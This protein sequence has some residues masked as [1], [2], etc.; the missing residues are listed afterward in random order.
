MA[1]PHPRPDAPRRLYRS[2]TERKIRGVCGGIAQYFGIDPRL[3]RIIAVM[4]L[5]VPGA[6]GLIAS[7]VAELTLPEEPVAPSEDGAEQPPE[8]QA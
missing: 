6:P 4:L 7:I 5:F 8:P 2:R 1:T 3:V